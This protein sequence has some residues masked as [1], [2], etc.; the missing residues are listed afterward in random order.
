MSKLDRVGNIDC[1]SATFPCSS[2]A[3]T[4][5]SL[6]ISRASKRSERHSSLVPFHEEA[7]K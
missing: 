3:E 2:R 1:S 4:L 5:T 7:S 6:G